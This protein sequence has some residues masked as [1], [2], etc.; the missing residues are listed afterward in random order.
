MKYLIESQRGKAQL[1]F[2][3]I[4][5][6][7]LVVFFIIVTGIVIGIK[8]YMSDTWFVYEAVTCCGSVCPKCFFTL[9]TITAILPWV[10]IAILLT[11]I[12]AAIY[13]AFYLSCRNYSFI[14]S[15]H[16]LSPENH[17]KLKN[18]MRRMRFHNQLV[19]LD[20]NE[21]HCAFTSGLW[22]PKVYLSLGICSYLTGKELLAVIL[23]EAQHKNNK[24][25]L[26]LFVIQIFYAL[27]FFLP[28]NHYL[29]S[30]FSSASEKAADDGA[31]NVSREPIELA[32]AL[33]K[34]CKSNQ[35]AILYS[36]ASCFNGQNIVEDRIRRLL[37]P[38]V[39]SP[40]L[41]KTYLYSSSLLS[42][43]IATTI[44]LSL[45]YKFFI[46]THIPDC[47]TRTCHMVRCG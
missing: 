15:H 1:Y 32:S 23:H 4:V 20:N 29:L 27:N 7:N 9:Y 37:E 42:L 47:K 34:I 35:T 40:Y 6:I 30:Q 28:I 44:C 19:L 46:P 10:C 3:L 21:L 41:F 14:R 31:I 26:K 24:D 43:F 8:G 22:K 16:S 39:A 18:I 13:K 17:P 25:P 12:C 2:S 38:Q 45:F 33:V 11:G 5:F 36:S